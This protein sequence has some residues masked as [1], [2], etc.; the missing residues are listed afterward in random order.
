MSPYLNIPPVTSRNQS[1]G[2]M[3]QN[4]VKMQAQLIHT[5]MRLM[6]HIP[7]LPEF[8]EKARQDISGTGKAYLYKLFRKL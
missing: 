2:K 4:I 3:D 5:C 6:K 8:M 7:V 1:N